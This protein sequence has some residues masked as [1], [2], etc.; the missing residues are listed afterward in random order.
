MN[1]ISQLKTLSFDK[2]YNYQTNVQLS[3]TTW[4]GV[5][6]LCD[7]VFKVDDQNTLQNFISDLPNEFKKN[8]MPIGVTS[9][10]L[11]R[12]EGFNGIIVKPKFLNINLIDKENCLIEVGSGV[13]DINLSKFAA[14]NSIS[15]LEFFYTI[16]G[17]VGGAIAMNAGCYGKEVSDVFISATGINCITGEIK[18]FSKDEMRFSYRHS[19][20]KNFIWTKATFMGESSRT[21]TEIYKKMDEFYQQRSDSQ[22]KSC[23]TGGST[24]CNPT[25]Y[26]AWDLID[27][28]GLR[29]YRIGGACFSEKHCN[30]II[31][32]KYA[33]A[34]DIID[35]IELAEKKVLEEFGIKLKR[36]IIII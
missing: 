7:I 10:L 5:G 30:F 18:T 25:G 27:K 9:N 23:K 26:K 8:I 19:G 28:V 22:P 4:F 36:E 2:K 33:K 17:T 35:L 13:L 34:Q 12:D 1:L 32:D 3:K 20:I 29:G 16:P 15:G 6:G 11:I 31:N 21:K 24:F 14:E